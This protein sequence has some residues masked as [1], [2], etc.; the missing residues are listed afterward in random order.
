LDRVEITQRV[1]NE[2]MANN[3]LLLNWLQ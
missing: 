3:L 1:I 2:L